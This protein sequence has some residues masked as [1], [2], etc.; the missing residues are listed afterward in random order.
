MFLFEVSNNDHAVSRADP[1]PTVT[2]DSVLASSVLGS[3]VLGSRGPGLQ[4]PAPEL[5]ATTRTTAASVGAPSRSAVSQGG[6]GGRSG[7]EATVLGVDAVPPPKLRAVDAYKRM[8]HGGTESMAAS[9]SLQ[10]TMH[11]V[12]EAALLRDVLFVFQGIDGKHVRF[13]PVADAY[14]GLFFYA[15]DSVLCTTTGSKPF[16]LIVFEP[17]TS[18]LQMFNSISVS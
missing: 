5:T 15:F 12:S 2:F 9:G 4:R 3:S 18:M 1:V 13:D 11:E 16:V 10:N 14:V 8:Q 7:R 6:E 17:I